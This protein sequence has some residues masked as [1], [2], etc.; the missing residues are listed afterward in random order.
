MR[1]KFPNISYLIAILLIVLLSCSP[2]EKKVNSVPVAM[3]ESRDVIL[4]RILSEGKLIASTDYNSTNY[5]VYRGEPLGYQYELLKSFADF[6]GVKLEIKIN[7]D[8]DASLKC[9]NA[10]ECDLIALGLTVTKDRLKWVDF[11]H[12]LIQTRQI[13]ESIKREKYPSY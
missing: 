11:S 2:N 12:P 1:Y 6:L 5:Y 9:I 4:D 10:K 7:N 8:L 3:V 13:G